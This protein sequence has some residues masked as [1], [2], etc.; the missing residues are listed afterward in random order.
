MSSAI[1]FKVV[2]PWLFI[3]RRADRAQ[4]SAPQTSHRLD[5]AEVMGSFLQDLISRRCTDS[6]NS[7]EK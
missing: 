7:A 6:V 1:F 3:F 5:N 4:I 2:S